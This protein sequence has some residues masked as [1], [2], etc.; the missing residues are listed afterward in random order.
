[1]ALHLRLRGL[2]GLRGL[3]DTSP[4]C[5]CAQ[6]YVGGDGGVRWLS[7]ALGAEAR[8]HALSGGVGEREEST[9]ASFGRR[10]GLAALNDTRRT[11]RRRRWRRRGPC[12]APNLCA[13]KRLGVQASAA[14]SPPQTGGAGGSP[15]RRARDTIAVAALQAPSA[16][17]TS[18]SGPGGR[19]SS[20]R[21]PKRIGGPSV[22]VLKGVGRKPRAPR[23]FGPTWPFE[24]GKYMD[25]LS[26]MR[27]VEL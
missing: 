16:Q 10:A 11:R 20:A 14:T 21:A 7:V 13:L 26:S 18:R 8:R 2:A 1:M 9:R 12:C 5:S 15:R 27:R 6:A 17:G 19:P 23:T 25:K 22:D 4:G 3:V 24:P